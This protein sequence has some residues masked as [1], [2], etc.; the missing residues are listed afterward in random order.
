[1]Q[2]VRNEDYN[3]QFHALVTQHGLQ[4]ELLSHDDIPKIPASLIT[5]FK[6]LPEIN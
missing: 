4:R 2:A 6:E 5:V 1:M 3:N